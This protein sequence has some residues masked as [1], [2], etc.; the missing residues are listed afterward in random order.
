M[1]QEQSLSGLQKALSWY[2]DQTVVC[3]ISWPDAACQVKRCYK[4]G[5]MRHQVLIGE[6]TKL[7]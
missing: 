4:A 5:S 6:E 2:V 1:R 3:S 7:V